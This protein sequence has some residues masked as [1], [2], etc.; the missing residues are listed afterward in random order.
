MQIIGN[1]SKNNVEQK[2]LGKS[3]MVILLQS[4]WFLIGSKNTNNLMKFNLTHKLQ[5]CA[6]NVLFI[7]ETFGGRFVFV[8]RLFIVKLLLIF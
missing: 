5:T 3:T 4:N 2:E 6:K 7:N 1:S 8:C